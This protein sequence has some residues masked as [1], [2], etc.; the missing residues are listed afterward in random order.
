MDTLSRRHFLK[1]TAAVGLSA[2]ML[3]IAEI[4]AQAAIRPMQPGTP[5]LVL[6]TLYG[7]NDGLNTVVPVNDPLYQNLRPGIAYSESDVLPLSDGLFLN[8]AMAGIK[9]LWDQNKVAIVRGVG[10]PKFDRS[11]FSSMAIWQSGSPSEQLKSGWIGRYLDTQSYDPLRVINIG[12]I[13]PPLM[14]GKKYVG[15]ALPLGGLKLP[16]AKLSKSI[17]MVTKPML[18]DSKL[19]ALA[20]SSVRN[21][22]NLSG[23]VTPV[24][25]Q[26][27]PVIPDL[28]T[29]DGGNAGGDTA[30]AQQLEIIAKLIEVGAPTKV[31]SASLG[32]FDT[33]S[34]EKGAQSVLLGTVSSAVSRFMKQVK[35]TNYGEN[36]TVMIYSEFGRR[37]VA[38]ASQGTDHGTS[39]P[40]FIIGDKVKGG[41]YGDQPSLKDL[42]KD[43]LP[44]TSDFRDIYATI[45][46]SIL[47]TPAGNLLSGWKSKT[48]FL[49]YK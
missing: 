5:I 33:H 1:L 47:G 49:L 6:I 46:E 22:I 45:S 41:F 39:G 2:P 10:Y 44:I 29:V 13:L 35:T 30:L 14:V 34:N 27:A 28:P 23:D 11:H 20:A 43:D 16:S 3:S 17:E 15:S 7:G 48:N 38:N 24:L 32:G 42:V 40:V 9:S 37:V 4:E 26:P 12:S 36:V 25:K 19:V 8:G 31:W 21:L 18:S